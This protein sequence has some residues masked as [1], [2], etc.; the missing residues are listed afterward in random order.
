MHDACATGTFARR[1]CRTKRIW[2]VN[3]SERF[4]VP[5][6]TK[7]TELVAAGAIGRVVQTVGMGPHRLNR[8]LRADWFST[9]IHY[10][11]I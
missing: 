1:R 11:G 9:A 7:A 8:A 5:S 3:F 4:E 2:S 6:V 10:G